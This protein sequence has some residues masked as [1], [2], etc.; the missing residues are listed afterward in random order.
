ML[1]PTNIVYK[2]TCNVGDC[3]LQN[4]TYIDMTTTTLSRR[5]TMHLAAGGPIESPH[6][7]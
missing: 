4:S 5:L 2:Y 6:A 3:E 7:K 1:M